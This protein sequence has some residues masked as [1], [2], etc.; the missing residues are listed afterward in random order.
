ME[1]A[2][3][4][5]NAG[6]ML[7]KALRL[8]YRKI[9]AQYGVAP[10]TLARLVN[11]GTSLS[12]FNA[13]KRALSPEEETMLLNYSHSPTDRAGIDV[14]WVDRY[15]ERNRDQLQPHWS[16]PLD[17]ACARALNPTIIDHWFN[18]I[19]QLEYVD[20]NIRPEDTY[21]MDESGFPPESARTQRVIV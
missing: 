19:V 15:I 4:A 17:T 2:I 12:V 8:R 9:A 11:S 16:K 13:T 5:Y 18:V 6:L 14:K 21:G 20:M 10:A 7:L 3:Q 1:L